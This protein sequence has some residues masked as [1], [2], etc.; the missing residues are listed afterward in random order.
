[1]AKTQTINPEIIR[2]RLQP[3]LSDFT[4]LM[5]KSYRL[6]M[7]RFRKLLSKQWKKPIIL[8][9][10]CGYKPFRSLFPKKCRYIGVDTDKNSFA[11]VIADNHSLP[12]KDSTFNA[13]IA[14][15]VLEHS[16][17]EYK[18]VSELRR[19][20]KN[21]ALVF[22]SLPFIFPEHGQPE[23]YQRFTQYKLRELF[24]KDEI[25]LLQPS[26][27]ITASVFIFINMF[28]RIMYGSSKILAPIYMVNNFLAIMAENMGNFF[29]RGYI[30]SALKSCPI[31]YSMIVKIKK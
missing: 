19:V 14:S 5:T 16:V 4:Y 13:V 18:F 15:E 22:I 9:L 23:D 27:N 17:N 29:A 12:F 1:M 30:A 24:K 26:N 3:Q 28:F 8:D 11:N 25:V 21:Q 2:E 10:G 31:G 7:D 20:C 6:T